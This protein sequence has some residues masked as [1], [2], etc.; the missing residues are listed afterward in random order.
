V[1]ILDRQRIDQWRHMV[2]QH[3]FLEGRVKD[4][5]EQYSQYEDDAK[6]NIKPGTCQISAGHVSDYTRSAKP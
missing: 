2:K 3:L 6:G 5:S 1:D 4:D